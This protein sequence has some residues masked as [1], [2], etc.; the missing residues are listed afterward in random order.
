MKHVLVLPSMLDCKWSG[1]GTFFT[2]QAVIMRHLADWKINMLMPCA[3][4]VLKIRRR[5]LPPA[6]GIEI[7]NINGV[8]IWIG[9]YPYYVPRKNRQAWQYFGEQLFCQYV[10]KHG[11]PDYIWAQGILNAGYLARHLKQKYSAP[12]FIHE[13]ARMYARE[14]LSR[15]LRARIKEIIQGAI[16]CAAVSKNLRINMLNQVLIDK[17]KI[18]VIHNPVGMEFSN[19]V[20]AER[21]N[22]QIFISTAYLRQNKNV[23]AII[24]AFALIYEKNKNVQLA[25]IGDGNEGEKLEQLTQEKE[26]HQVVKFYGAQSREQIY[27][28][29]QTADFFVAASD[30]ETFGVALVES[31]VCGLPAISAKVGIAEEIIDE[32]TGILIESSSVENIAVAMQTIMNR[33][34]D[35][36][37]IREKALSISHPKIFAQRVERNLSCTEK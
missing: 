31:M 10:K 9:Y 1:G 23:D 13:H 36:A 34:Y 32:N 20:L 30:Y 18:C 26:L 27:A 21:H 29:L 12:Y 16:Y 14:K 15:F 35:S 3:K 28:H 5:K 7:K 37:L 2:E 22:K 24:R 11:M 19:A 8:E 6:H 33:R 4:H 25:I 17:E